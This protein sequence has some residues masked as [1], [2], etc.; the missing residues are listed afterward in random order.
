MSSADTGV[1]LRILEHALG[2][3]FVRIRLTL[4][5]FLV[6][7]RTPDFDPVEDTDD[8]DFFFNAGVFQEFLGKG[9]S[10]LTVEL[11]FCRPLGKRAHEE[12]MLRVRKREFAE[13]LFQPVPLVLG[14]DRKAFFK[15]PCNRERVI[16]V[17]G[18]TFAKLRWKRNSSFVINGVCEPALE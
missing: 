17:G 18:H 13:R 1:Q 4:L 9:Y 3:C 7:L 2:D 8:Q 11:A 5:I 16:R 12:S 14:I 6:D 15:S 10:L